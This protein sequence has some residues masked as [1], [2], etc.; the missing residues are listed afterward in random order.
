QRDEIKRVNDMY[1]DIHVLAGVE[2]DILPNGTLDFEDDFLK[3]MDI[4][5]A[6]IHSSFQQSESQIMD[7]LL[8]AM[9]NQYV[10]IIAHPTVRII[11]RI[12]GSYVHIYP[13]LH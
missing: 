8:P 7:R 13:L 3:E 12:D 10:D 4:V 9:E 6:A 1:D 2:M 5:I 11:V